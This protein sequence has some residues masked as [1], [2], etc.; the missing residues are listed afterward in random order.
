[1]KYDGRNSERVLFAIVLALAILLAILTGCKGVNFQHM[2]VGGITL[3]D[4]LYIQYRRIAGPE[5]VGGWHYEANPYKFPQPRQVEQYCN[6]RA[7]RQVQTLALWCY[8][9]GYTAEMLLLQRKGWSAHP[10]CEVRLP[11]G[12]V[13]FDPGL[14]QVYT[15]LD[16]W[17]VFHPLLSMA[18]IKRNQFKRIGLK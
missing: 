16:D 1:M 13:Y 9:K 3:P 5:V 15:R 17:K 14:H 7:L 11:Q 10:V 4:D 12:L 6:R 8:E 18:V 2:R